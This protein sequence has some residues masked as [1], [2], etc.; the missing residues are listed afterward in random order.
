MSGNPSTK[1]PFARRALPR[2]A[3]LAVVGTMLATAPTAAYA[4]PPAVGGSGLGD[5]Y[6]PNYGNSGYDVD[7]YNINVDYQPQG[8]L[9]NGTTTITAKATQDLRRFNLDF[10]LKVRSVTVNGKAATFDQSDP[11]ELV[12]TPK[13]PLR[14]GDPMV[15]KVDYFGVPSAVTVNGINPWIKTPDGAIALGEPE[16]SAWWF[17]ANDHPKDKAKYDITIKVPSGVE[18]ISGGQLVS[19]TLTPQGDTWQ[20]RQDKP[21]TTY[22]AFM[23]IGQFEV[24]QSTTARGLP[25]INAVATGNDPR[26]LAA[27]ADFART[28]EVLDF[29]S[30]QFGPYP[31]DA[32]GNVAPAADFG[33]A[34]ETQ[35][36]PVYTRGFW[37][38]GSNMGVVVHEHAHQWWGDSVAV[39]YWND[40]YVNEAFAT[41]SEWLWSENQGQGTAQQ[42]LQQTYDSYAASDPFWQVSIGDPGADKVFDNAVYDRGAMSLQALRNRVG[43]PAFWQILRTWQAEKANGNGS[44]EEFI[45]LAKKLSGENLDGFFQAW[46]YDQRKPAATAENGLDFGTPK[47]VQQT[48]AQGKVAAPA[49]AEKVTATRAQQVETHRQLNEK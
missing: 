21:M 14:N 33:Y 4:G 28:G 13:K 49:A 27:K 43:S 26:I 22:L 11:H 23:A 40:I 48:N 45:A 18:A 2:L 5:D 35:T 39:E 38:R 42:L 37:R 15:V 1:R 25:M 34:L 19:R 7:R 9:L 29:L 24:T 17:P 10:A 32:T 30:S 46:L 31:F 36:R 8:D 44:T 20:W 6:F 47:A 3:T 41:Y 12:V 16:I